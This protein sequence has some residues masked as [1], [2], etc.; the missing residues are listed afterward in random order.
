MSNNMDIIYTKEKPEVDVIYSRESKGYSKKNEKK[1]KKA[2]E[3]SVKSEKV[4]PTKNEPQYEKRDEK[5]IDMFWLGV[6]VAVIA[7]SLAVGLYKKISDKIEESR[8]EERV[9]KYLE[10]NLEVDE[11]LKDAMWYTFDEQGQCNQWGYNQNT[12]ARYINNSESDS[13]FDKKLYA[14][15]SKAGE[16]N[17]DETLKI[18][19]GMDIDTYLKE[20]GYVDKSGKPSKSVWEEIIEKEIEREIEA[21]KMKKNIEGKTNS[22]IIVAANVRK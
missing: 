17:A 2:Y 15:Y 1:Y 16:W 5:S 3:K 21:E 22:D 10:K 6:T 4:Q 18:A 19:Q 7:S 8:Q 12:L 14:V 13:E 11:A 9:Q 20:N